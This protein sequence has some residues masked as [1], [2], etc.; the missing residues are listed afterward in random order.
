VRR[1][2]CFR[3]LNWPQSI[4]L[5]VTDFRQKG[6]DVGENEIAAAHRC[7]VAQTR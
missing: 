6:F 1:R 7:Y 4:A 2:V 5:A 3:D